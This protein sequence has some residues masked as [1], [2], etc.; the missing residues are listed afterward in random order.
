V[1]ARTVLASSTGMETEGVCVVRGG[2][3][4]SGDATA[5]PIPCAHRNAWNSTIGLLAGVGHSRQYRFAISK[6]EIVY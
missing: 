6:S 5:V 1:R 2:T 3:P 4:D